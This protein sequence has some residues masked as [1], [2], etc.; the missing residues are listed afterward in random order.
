MDT[1]GL[2]I[3]VI[4]FVLM[5]LG[6]PLFVALGLAGVGV[7][8]LSANFPMSSTADF[9][10]TNINIFTLL[11][12]PLFIFAGYLMLYGG[13]SK[14]LVTVMNAFFGNVPGGL[15]VASVIAC[16][17]FG[18]ISGSSF[19]CAAAIGVIMIPAMLE[20]GYGEDE[21]TGVIAT[22]SGLGNL[23]PPSLF[24]ILYGALVETS[25]GQ[26]FIAGIMPGI[27]LAVLMSI[28]AIIVAVRRGHKGKPAASWKVR[29]V[30]FLKALP[31]IFM[32]VF[33]LGGIYGGIFTPTEAAAV[34]S[35]YAVVCGF[36][37]Y[38]ELTLARLW[39]TCHETVKTTGMIFIMLAGASLLGKMFIFVGIPQAI[40]AWVVT[41]ELGVSV[42][43][44]LSIV[45]LIILGCIMDTLAIMYITVPLL[46]PTMLL[47]G[48]SPIHFGVIM[49]MALL[50]ATVTP[51]VG[52]AV[53]F[54]AGLAK[55][56]TMKT[57]RGSMPYLVAMIIALVLVTYFPQ[58]SLWLLGSMG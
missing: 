15:A 3:I 16:A 50:V 36:F 32:P 24:F 51:P 57:M 49:V 55:V 44:G 48:V 23:I 47:L 17:F 1:T 19:A 39:Q 10:F 20:E 27:L 5:F 41:T 13:S 22:S 34:S 52:I 2:V 25:V 46:F 53:Y 26:L 6:F 56:P 18:A 11:A 28:V 21:A 14:R 31:A 45:V 12:L 8:L 29:G 37:I 33:V 42:F 43:L 58:I 40:T 4:S 38:R 30:A 54:I 9:F 7:A 35:L